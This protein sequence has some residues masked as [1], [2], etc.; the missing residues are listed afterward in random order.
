MLNR[1]GGSLVWSFQ[2][3]SPRVQFPVSSLG[4]TQKQL[5]NPT[6]KAQRA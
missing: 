5:S 1:L 2:V 6:K 3:T 4:S